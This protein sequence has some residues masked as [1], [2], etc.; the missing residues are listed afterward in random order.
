MADA[1]KLQRRLPE[2]PIEFSEDVQEEV[3]PLIR[4]D[5]A[6]WTAPS[7]CEVE[8]VGSRCNVQFYSPKIEKP[9]AEEEF[10][11]VVERATEEPCFIA[12][13]SPAL[14]KGRRRVF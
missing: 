1:R 7:F 2:R 12:S 8:A 6:M 4:L 3:V 13:G 11:Q 10:D 5:C 14:A 9:D